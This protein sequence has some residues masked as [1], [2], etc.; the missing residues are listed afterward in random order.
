MM[1]LVPIDVIISSGEAN[2]ES[3]VNLDNPHFIMDELRDVVGVTVLQASIPFSYY[4]F[5]NLT[6]QFQITV[7]GGTSPPQATYRCTIAAG[8]YNSINL[9]PQLN[10][11]LSNAVNTATQAVVN[12][13]AAGF[14]SWV[15]TSTSRLVVLN[16]LN[17]GVSGSGG[18]FNVNFPST[19]NS[20][21]DILGF[22]GAPTTASVSTA[23]VPLL[24]NNE[25]AQSGNY[26]TSPF[27]VNLSG[28]NLLFLHSSLASSVYGTVRTHTN[29]SD[30]LQFITVN[31]N[32][33]GMIEWVN[34]NPTEMKPM[35]RNTITKATFYFT[36][37]FRLRFQAGSVERQ[38]L[39]FN[40]QTFQ[41]ALRFYQINDAK[42][43]Y[44]SNRLGD[45][46]IRASSQTG[47]TMAP[48]QTRNFQIVEGQG[49]KR[50]AAP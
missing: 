15:D 25:V 6:N 34:P 16:F 40:G 3:V 24:D 49:K 5:D 4:V 32:Y 23:S 28:E 46:A 45:R 29:A 41:L 12:L 27:S 44:I 36:L 43:D 9:I 39:E 13:A 26:V 10:N 47:T 42:I 33:Q 1:D 30:I 22:Y 17:P 31:N 18:A 11:A 20:A 38:Y 50:R 19:I 48:Q 35:T 7:T 21:S 37:G 14:R 8:S 2:G